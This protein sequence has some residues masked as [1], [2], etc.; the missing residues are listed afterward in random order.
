MVV[1]SAYGDLDNILVQVHQLHEKDG[2][3]GE[4]NS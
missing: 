4:D 2:W 1:V 3:R